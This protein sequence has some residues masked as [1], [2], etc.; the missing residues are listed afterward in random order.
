VAVEYFLVA[1]A[2]GGFAAEAQT[3]MMERLRTR[4]HFEVNDLLL[5]FPSAEAL[6]SYVHRRQGKF[7]EF[8]IE[9]HPAV[10]VGAE[11][12]LSTVGGE[13]D[14]L[15]LEFALFCKAHWPCRLDGYGDRKDLPL[16]ELL[17]FKAK[18]DD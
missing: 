11:V 18:G 2:S 17:W 14:R 3:Q 10:R 12:M 16:D 8:D 5:L 6:Q 15:L 1:E 13:E 4:P 7:V 9:L